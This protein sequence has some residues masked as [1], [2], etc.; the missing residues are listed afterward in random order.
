MRKGQPN[1]NIFRKARRLFSKL[2]N[3]QII[4]ITYFLV[5]IISACL[6]LVPAAQTG[7]V[8][9]TFVDALFT[10]ASAFSDTGL[11]TV[12]TVET[13]TGFGQFII[14]LLIL[15]GGIGIFALKVY[16]I[17]IIFRRQISINSRGVLEKERG[18]KNSNEIKSTIKIS[19]TFIFIT[20]I[21]AALIL[22]PM[23]YYQKGNFEWTTFYRDENDGH[24]I[25]N[26]PVDFSQ[27]DPY[28]DVALSFKNAI[29]HSISAINNAG[30][31]ILSAAS[32]TPYYGVYSIQIVFII[33]LVLGGIGFPVI[34]DVLR[35]IHHKVKHRT[36]FKF[37]LFTKVSCVTY[38][39]VFIIGLSFTLLFDMSASNGI[40]KEQAYGTWGKVD[41][42]NQ[43]QSNYKDM[44][45]SKGDRMMCIFF[46]AFS[47]RNAGFT[48]LDSN[49][50]KFTS[51]S[52][53][54]FAIMMFIGSAPS[55]TAGGI[56]T[57]TLAIL[58]VA[59]WNRMRGITKVRMFKR[60]VSNAT[61]YSSFMVFVI[62]IIMVL[63]VSLLC[64]TSYENMGMW[65]TVDYNTINYADILYDV[66]SAFGTTGLSTGM[67]SGLNVFSKIII[68]FV[69]FIGQ[70]G[71]S[72]TML[73][74][75]KNNNK[76]NYSYIEEEIMVG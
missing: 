14:C 24:Y 72:S 39:S 16:I 69:M 2:S 56:R 57:T 20:I 7:D 61:V 32:L 48:T 52:L 70:L 10:A 33:L 43:I 31:D 26:D 9:V 27:Y 65:G 46:H 62:S 44:L 1:K 28:H 76:D 36:D 71:I 6:L 30:F 67:I 75:R 34:Y 11:T 15:L 51:P 12:T 68:I 55:S 25:L 29:F 49:A 73:V 45:G 41:T 38:L 66:C 8:E 53:I 5:T 21:I 13:W 50:A 3:L 35:F 64:C 63:L 40:W 23:F 47:T 54:I 37:S 42:V 18:A 58:F 17:N 59:I 4:L 60:N 74:W 22:W 19:I